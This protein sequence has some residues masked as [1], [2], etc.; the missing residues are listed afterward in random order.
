MPLPNGP[1][2]D[3]GKRTPAAQAS[4]IIVAAGSSQRMGGVDKLFA[5]VCGRPLLHHTVSAFESCDAINHIMLVLSLDAAPAGLRLLKAGRFKKVD[6]TCAGGARRQDSVRAG[7]SAL[8]A[9][10]WVVVHDAARPLVTARLIEEGIAKAQTTGAASAA[11]P[12]SDTL[13][14]VGSDETVLWTVARDR[15]WAAQTPQVF[16]YD[17]LLRAHEQEDL[18]ASDDAGL[19]EQ[20]GGRVR[21][22][23]GSA[24]NIKVTT[25]DD[26]VLVEALLT[27][28]NTA[29]G[30]R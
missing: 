29:A 30:T 14:E 22:Y 24:N 2:G 11:L 6:G 8:R 25:P 9:C 23:R 10:D 27:L 15:L 4:A 16:R 18:E 1:V 13:K 5:D 7:L 12:V 19:V 20:I 26:L 17:L 21:V 28:R 3:E